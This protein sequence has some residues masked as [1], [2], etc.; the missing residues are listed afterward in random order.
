[1][2]V[3]VWQAPNT[4]ANHLTMVAESGSFTMAGTDTSTKAAFNITAGSGVYTLTGASISLLYSSSERQ[5]IGTVTAG[6]KPD[7]IT[8]T[9]KV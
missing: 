5:V 4:W 8:V 9:F 2:S 7:Q 1:M 3:N 6:Y